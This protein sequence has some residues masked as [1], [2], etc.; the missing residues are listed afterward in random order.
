[1]KYRRILDIWHYAAIEADTPSYYN[2][3]PVLLPDRL[4]WGDPFSDRFVGGAAGL[5]LV[6]FWS[7]ILST[8]CLFRDR[9]TLIYHNFL[10]G[11]YIVF[12]RFVYEDMVR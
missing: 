1:M 9:K 11:F 4:I 5:V 10:H 7:R 6:D 2:A 8:M 3:L 12:H